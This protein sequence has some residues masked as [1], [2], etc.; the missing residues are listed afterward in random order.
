LKS[1]PNRLRSVARVATAAIALAT[2]VVAFSPTDGR[3]SPS[4]A[5]AQSSLRASIRAALQNPDALT[6]ATSLL[7]AMSAV[8]AS[9][10]EEVVTA[11]EEQLV[12]RGDWEHELTLL[13]ELWV[14]ISPE[15]AFARVLHGWNDLDPQH[16][17]IDAVTRAW[18]RSDPTSAS[19]AIAGLEPGSIRNAALNGLALGWAES[20]DPGIWEHIA[21]TGPNALE[22][23]RVMIQAMRAIMN[24]EG[25]DSLFSKVAA[26]PDDMNNNFKLHAFRSAGS[27]VARVEPDR[28]MAFAE[29]HADGPYSK[30]LFA[31]VAQ[32]L[33]ESDGASAMEW[34]SRLES[35]PQRDH[36][37][38]EAYR[39]WRIER[40][41]EADLWLEG[42]RNED[43]LTPVLPLQ[44]MFLA[45]TKG[46]PVAMA[47]SRQISDPEVRNT[48]LVQVG[49]YWIQTEPEAARVG[50]AEIDL[51]TTV[52][53]RLAQI[54]QK[55][56]PDAK[57][58][59]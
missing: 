15:G 36:A 35:G 46:G 28:A 44:A 45:Q 56:R 10:I 19:L 58:T 9:S 59:P 21:Q 7:E 40:E 20:G 11:F 14:P 27:L 53:T 2:A 37:I 54:E 1:K 33:V 52:E 8:D 42:R 16:H 30:N 32:R 18:S 49:L 3:A 13:A 26:L 22:R 43:W 57:S 24:L 51:L 48:A 34:L 23:E 12:D 31:R 6:R 50:L 17:G 47:W 29:R 38:F 55:R 41:P 25:V 4:G 39:R 5:S